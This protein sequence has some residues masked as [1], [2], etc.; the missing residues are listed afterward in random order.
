MHNPLQEV[1]VPRVRPGND[2]ASS[3]TAVVTRGG[4]ITA[5]FTGRVIMIAF[6]LSFSLAAGIVV[7][8]R[9]P[10]EHAPTLPAFL[11][12][13]GIGLIAWAV[14]TAVILLAAGAILYRFMPRRRP[15]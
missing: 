6:I 8:Y 2:G 13:L 4:K 7:M 9:K 5:Y 14:A 11:S 10:D 1:L 12:T 15:R 3:S